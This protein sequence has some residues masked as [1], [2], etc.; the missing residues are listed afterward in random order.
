MVC[1]FVVLCIQ[2]QPEA[3]SRCDNFACCR[4]RTC[5]NSVLTTCTAAARLQ[6]WGYW[7]AWSTVSNIDE[8]GPGPAELE[9]MS[10]GGPMQTWM[11]VHNVSPCFC[12]WLSLIV[13]SRQHHSTSCLSTS[14][15]RD[16]YVVQRYWCG[17]G[18]FCQFHM[19][20]AMLKPK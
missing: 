3:E 1:G 7:H 9:R 4:T 18:K 15:P 19:A 13:N 5:T 16:G 2:R 11:F 14:N 6:D 20:L 8:V 10:P 17:C 12:F